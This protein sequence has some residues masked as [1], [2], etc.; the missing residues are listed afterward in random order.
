MGELLLAHGA[1]VNFGIENVEISKEFYNYPE[2]LSTGTWTTGRLGIF[3]L[4]GGWREGIEITEDLTGAGSA[5][6][7][8]LNNFFLTA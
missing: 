7:D 8:K 1:P 2:A 3:F 5:A 6:E 4:L